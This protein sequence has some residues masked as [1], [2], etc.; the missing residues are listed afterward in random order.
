MAPKPNPRTDIAYV[1][2]SNERRMCAADCGIAITSR[3]GWV[4]DAI[5]R[6]YHHGCFGVGPVPEVSGQDGACRTFVVSGLADDGDALMARDDT[7]KHSFTY[8][9]WSYNDERAYLLC[10]CGARTV[11]PCAYPKEGGDN[12][13]QAASGD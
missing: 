2:A 10:E 8:E 12:A 13:R 11:V 5:G 1:E 3:T 7:H 6:R 4:E 9:E